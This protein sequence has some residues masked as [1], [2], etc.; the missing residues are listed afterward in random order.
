MLNK[1]IMKLLV[2]VGMGF[3]FGIGAG[4]WM[5][6][7]SLST[8]KSPFKIEQKDSDIIVHLRDKPIIRLK[9]QVT[10]YKFFATGEND[11]WQ[12]AVVVG[13]VDLDGLA[14]LTW[15]RAIKADTIIWNWSSE[16]GKI[17]EE[18]RSEALRFGDVFVK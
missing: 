9:D 18:K 4:L 17:S 7:L 12:R 2:F 8:R 13:S 14:F 3:L 10:H 5:N 6:H 16:D 1:E 11:P 15:Q